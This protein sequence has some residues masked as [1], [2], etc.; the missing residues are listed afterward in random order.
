L[1]GVP[2]FQKKTLTLKIV[3]MITVSKFPS[4]AVIIRP[5]NKATLLTFFKNP[6]GIIVSS[7]GITTG[8]AMAM[9]TSL[10]LPVYFVRSEIVDLDLG[11]EPVEY[12]LD[13]SFMCFSL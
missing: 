3:V 13:F 4:Q 7:A 8:E 9:V 2:F 12:Q 10:G 11:A 5:C 6:Q 1:P